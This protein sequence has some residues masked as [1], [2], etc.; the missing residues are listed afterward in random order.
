MLKLVSYQQ[1]SHYDPQM[2]GEALCIIGYTGQGTYTIRAPK[3][4]E[5]KKRREQKEELLARI[6]AAIEKGQPPGEVSM[7]DPRPERLDDDSFDVGEY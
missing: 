7:S 3:A 2:D 4:P 1:M 6:A 5:G